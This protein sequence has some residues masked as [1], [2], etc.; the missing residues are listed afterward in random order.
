MIIATPEHWHHRMVLD[1]IAAGKDMYVEKP[2]CQTPQ[3]GVELVEAA[4][5]SKSVIQVGTQRRSYDL[6]LKA[7]DIVRQGT[8]GNVRMVRSWWLN[9]MIDP[10]G[11]T[12]KGPLDWEQWQGPAQKRPMDPA[13]ISSIGVS[14]PTTRA[15]WPPIRERTFTTE[16]PC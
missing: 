5:R 10:P 4:K 3:Q 15:A 9:N 13:P 6:Y 12:L 8:L 7:R 14:T 2:L 11:G 16:S 1:A